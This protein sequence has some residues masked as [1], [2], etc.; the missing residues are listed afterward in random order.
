MYRKDVCVTHDGVGQCESDDDLDLERCDV[1]V[2][3]DVLHRVEQVHV[4]FRRL[5]RHCSRDCSV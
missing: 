3:G 2:H 1:S 4:A 5:G